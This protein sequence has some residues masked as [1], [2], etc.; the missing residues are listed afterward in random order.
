MTDECG[1]DGAHRVADG[2]HAMM[3]GVGGAAVPRGADFIRPI[4]LDVE[5]NV[6]P[7]SNKNAGLSLACGHHLLLMAVAVKVCEDDVERHAPRIE[8]DGR[9]QIQAA[10]VG[11]TV[12]EVALERGHVPV[13]GAK[14]DHEQRRHAVAVMITKT[15]V[16]RGE[17]VVIGVF[18]D[19][20]RVPVVDGNHVFQIPCSGDEIG[21]PVAVKVHRE[22]ASAKVVESVW[23]L[24]L[25]NE[26]AV[27]A[28]L[29]ALMGTPSA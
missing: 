9:G 3:R 17:R 15:R 5:A 23:A 2:E 28:Q 13:A 24:C 4:A 21:V 22:H 10:P 11:W 16:G 20:P 12:G 29:P 19:L 27:E 8:L 25:F 7:A 18:A 26:A 1:L 14:F 6:V